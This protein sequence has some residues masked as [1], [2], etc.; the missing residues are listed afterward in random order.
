MRK[1]TRLLAVIGVGCAAACLSSASG[2]PV[3]HVLA[4]HLFPADNA[5]VPGVPLILT[6]AAPNGYALTKA[7]NDP[8]SSYPFGF[9]I[10]SP[11]TAT[12]IRRTVG[13]PNSVIPTCHPILNINSN[14]ILFDSLRFQNSGSESS[15]AEFDRGGCPPDICWQACSFGTPSTWLWWHSDD[16][17]SVNVVDGFHTELDPSETILMHR[18]ADGTYR[19]V[20]TQ[21]PNTSGV[22][23]P[24]INSS[25]MIVSATSLV[26]QYS[27][28]GNAYIPQIVL[29][30]GEGCMQSLDT[31][32]F[33][34]CEDGTIVGLGQWNCD[35][36]NSPSS[37]ALFVKRV[38]ES[39]RVYF[40]PSGTA[41]IGVQSEPFAAP[42]QP[43]KLRWAI[44][45]SNTA[46]GGGTVTQ[47]FAGQD[48]L[49]DADGLISWA[50]YE[51]KRGSQMV[52]CEGTTL[53]PAPATGIEGYVWSW[54]GVDSLGRVHY[55]RAVD[56][57]ATFDPVGLTVD[58]TYQFVRYEF[59]RTCPAD[60]NGDGLVDDFDF[61][62]FVTEYGKLLIPPAHP[63][64]DL[65]LD[66]QVDDVDFGLF[67]EAYDALL[68]P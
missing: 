35:P 15:F 27:W 43:H 66:G 33:F 23:T 58:R 40:P 3:E 12:A 29:A 11:T 54:A 56:D 68:C 6:F 14:G 32:N 5:D 8:S 59:E 64:A 36:L 41:S 38:G 13:L 61:N 60:F 62:I 50:S 52:L 34:L 9:W 22:G 7:P 39:I 67:G 1:Q 20:A 53:C 24:R 48:L 44:A 17:A 42:G 19:R 28:D 47:I 10:A 37:L 65:T 46:P 16:G 57:R 45:A 26:T 4:S 21:Y 55:V 18:L 51:I 30:N 25:G 2:Q 63:V 31:A 49:N